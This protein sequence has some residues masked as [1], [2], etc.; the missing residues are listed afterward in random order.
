MPGNSAGR[1][2]LS[3]KEAEWSSIL[4]PG[5]KLRREYEGLGDVCGMVG[6]SD[7]CIVI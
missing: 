4:R 7:Y 5:T 1:G 6:R 3:Y 2:D